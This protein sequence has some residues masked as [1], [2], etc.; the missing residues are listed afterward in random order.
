MAVMGSEG[1][2]TE[3]VAYIELIVFIGLSKVHTSLRKFY[4]CLRVSSGEYLNFRINKKLRK[5]DIQSSS[6]YF[7]QTDKETQQNIHTIMYLHKH[8]TECK[9]HSSRKKTDN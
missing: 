4:S 6:K 9:H 3:N 1:R 5:I 2:F 7:S 8:T